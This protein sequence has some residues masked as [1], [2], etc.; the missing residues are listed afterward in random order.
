M[1]AAGVE[2]KN[3]DLRPDTSLFSMD[4]INSISIG[5]GMRAQIVAEEGEEENSCEAV[6]GAGMDFTNN[7]GCI[8][9][10]GD[11]NFVQKLNFGNGL[12]FG[13]GGGDDVGSRTVNVKLQVGGF[14][15]NGTIGLGNC[16][17]AIQGSPSGDCD[18][19][20]ISVDYPTGGGDGF[21]VITDVWSTDDGIF[22]KKRKIYFCGS[23]GTET[24]SEV[25]AFTDCSG[26]Y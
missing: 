25:V 2:L 13:S 19:V 7:N 4:F 5:K 21:E 26:G 16:L 23:G 10:P 9:T 1:I 24:Q 11:A 20:I 14:P 17:K 12:E 22:K 18:S 6:V 15:T 3:N 8:T